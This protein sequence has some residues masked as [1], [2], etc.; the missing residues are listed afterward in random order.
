M[1]SAFSA[2][3]HLHFQLA[4]AVCLFVVFYGTKETNILE[5]AKLVSSLGGPLLPFT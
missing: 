3:F 2:L 4:A 5:M 1:V